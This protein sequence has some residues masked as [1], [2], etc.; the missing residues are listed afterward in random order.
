MKINKLGIINKNAI[1]NS[2]VLLLSQRN[3]PLTNSFIFGD[4]QCLEVPIYNVFNKCVNKEKV[5]N[6]FSHFFK[7]IMSYLL[8]KEV[9]LYKTKLGESEICLVSKSVINLKEKSSYLEL[10]NLFG[11]PKCCIQRYIQDGN[12]DSDSF[13]SAE[14]YLKQI[15]KSNLEDDPFGVIIN[16]EIKFSSGGGKYNFIPCNPKCKKALKSKNKID[17]I[18]REVLEERGIL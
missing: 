1:F 10:G 12:K 9:Y 2:V 16:K 15:N 14:R 5:N 7:D 6:L 13:V 3:N 17:N 4:K 18:N 11:I 8:R